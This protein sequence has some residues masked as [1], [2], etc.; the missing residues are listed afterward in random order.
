M[1]NLADVNG[2]SYSL[3]EALYRG[4]PV[5]V[6]DLPYFKEIGI[7]NNVNALF[8]NLDN[9]NAEDVAKRMQKPLKFKF[10]PIEDGYKDILV[11]SKSHYILDKS[12]RFKV[13]ATDTYSK[14]KMIDGQLGRTPEPGEEWIVDEERL[15]NLLGDNPYRRKYAEL[16]CEVNQN[17]QK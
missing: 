10:E 2:D 5:V 15:E 1:Y 3:R 11:K 13:R 17:T 4:L 12:K 9:S 6:C 14:L 8:Y 16:I 7:K